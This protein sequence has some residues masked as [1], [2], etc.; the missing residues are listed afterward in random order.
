MFL[1]KAE[2]LGCSST[3]SLCFI[4]EHNDICCPLS[5]QIFIHAFIHLVNVY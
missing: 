2:D 3:V 1:T 4:Y 5:L